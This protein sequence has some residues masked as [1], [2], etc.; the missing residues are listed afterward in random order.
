MIVF[1][2]LTFYHLVGLFIFD[3]FWK[4]GYLAYLLSQPSWSEIVFGGPVPTRILFTLV[5]R[6]T[7]RTQKAVGTVPN[8]YNLF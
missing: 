2:H 8:G 1:I 5:I 4:G 7:R 3:I 6:Q